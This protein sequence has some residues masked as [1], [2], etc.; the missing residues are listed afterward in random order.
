MTIK[1]I[2][3]SRIP[4]SIFAKAPIAGRV[5]TRLQ[6]HCTEGQAAEIAT[7][8]LRETVRRCHLY[9]PGELV[10]SIDDHPEHPVIQQLAQGYNLRVE[11]QAPGDLGER[12]GH[13]FKQGVTP[14]AIIGADASLIT[15]DILTQC[16]TLLAASHAVIGPSEDGGYYLI[17]LPTPTP[18]LFQGVNWGTAQVLAQTLQ[19]ASQHKLHLV[20]LPALMDVDEWPDVLRA[21][22]QIPELS[23]Y[24]RQQRLN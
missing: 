13:S 3:A 5:K 14:A 16:H 2:K 10:L 22:A 4:L 8:L 19:R 15:P 6:S 1:K 17:G 24:L 23:L 9:W 20:T 7:V 21:A 12:M 18:E 11:L